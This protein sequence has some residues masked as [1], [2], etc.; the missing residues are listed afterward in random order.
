MVCKMGAILYQLNHKCISDTMLAQKLIKQS[1]NTPETAQCCA[2][3]FYVMARVYFLWI[4]VI[5]LLKNHF[6]VAGQLILA[7]I[8]KQRG[9]VLK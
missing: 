4:I 9:N 5:Y 6:T 7:L 1:R 2:R 3:S 8:P